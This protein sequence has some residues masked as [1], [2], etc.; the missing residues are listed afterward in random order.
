MPKPARIDRPVS[1]TLSLPSSIVNRVDLALYSEVEQR[2][3]HGEWARLVTQLLTQKFVTS[4]Q[5][6]APIREM[7]Q[8]DGM[9]I[10]RHRDPEMWQYH[11]DNCAALLLRQ[12]GMGDL[13]DV[14]YGAEAGRAL[15]NLREGD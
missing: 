4:P 7:F 15:M 14:M 5:V 11:R 1:K 3:P 8:K 9:K 10:L 6:T 12:H 13:A 2:V